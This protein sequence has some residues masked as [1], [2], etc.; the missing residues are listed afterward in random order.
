[1]IQRVAKRRNGYSL[2]EIL[3]CIALLAALFPAASKFFVSISRLHTAQTAT[4]DRM[5]VFEQL[6][7]ELRADARAAIAIEPNFGAYKTEKRS[8]ILRTR[9]NVV[10]YTVDGQFQPQRIQFTTLP[11]GNWEQRITT[12]PPTRWRSRFTAN[13]RLAE[14]TARSGRAGAPEIHVAAAVGVYGG[15]TQ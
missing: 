13:G 4:L 8:L 12:Y 11:D 10:V 14:F 6:E 3:A 7:R 15:P 9:E 5:F 1:M 2:I